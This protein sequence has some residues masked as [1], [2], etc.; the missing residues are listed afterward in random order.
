MDH[1][2]WE[3]LKDWLV[4]LKVID[5]S[6]TSAKMIKRLD[7]SGHSLS[8]LPDNFG[9]LSE[10]ITL[11]LS[12]NHLQALPD[13][14]SS[15]ANLSN[16]DIRRNRFS[17]LP[18]V[19]SSLPLR[20]LNASGNMLDDVSELKGCNGIRVLDLSVNG[21]TT[22]DCV[23]DRKNELRTLNLSHNYLKNAINLFSQLPDTERLDL[24]GNMINNIPETIATMKKLVDLKITD[25]VIEYLDDKLFDLPIEK[26][27]LSSNKIYWIRLEG[28]E[29]LENVV[30][31]FNPIKH[32]EV[33]D[34]FAPYLKEFSC[35]GCGLKSF[36][37]I[38]S[39][40]LTQLCYSSNE[41]KVV[42]DYISQYTQLNELDLDGNLIVD[43]PDSMG[44]L[45]QLKTLYIEGNPLS[46]SAK[47]V[48]DILHPEICD[49]HMKRGITIEKANE[50]DLVQM[51]ELLSVLFA[52]E[53]DFDI[54]FDKQLSGIKK[55]FQYEG[56]ELLV[57]KHEGN[58]VGMV[59]MQRLVSSAEGDYIGQIED[60]VVKESYRKMGVGSR[61]LNKMRAIAQELGYKRIQLAADIDNENAL[62][63]YSR[64]GFHQTHLKVY[65]YNA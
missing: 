12:N 52:I 57:A 27:D 58:V 1:T 59:T 4:G 28:L 42:P 65:H 16:L 45:T 63:F 26:L 30:L 44:N 41:I 17:K 19:L 47:R 7:L 36:V 9:M 2:E 55:L 64:R 15:I 29:E 39:K 24:S 35:D 37:P 25:N 34:D 61:L 18:K 38:Q 43:L 62:Q 50:E 11:N 53:Q 54:D 21:I 3:S 23:F 10:L 5:V 56:K 6:I 51:A 22:V 40:E 46:E 60:L 49:I 14:M 48:I 33:S 20:S 31:D 13:S 8:E 32:I